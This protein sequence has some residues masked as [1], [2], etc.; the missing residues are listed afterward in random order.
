MCTRRR[1]TGREREQTLL[2]APTGVL[3]AA[4]SVSVLQSMPCTSASSDDQQARAPP[5]PALPSLNRERGSHLLIWQQ[6]SLSTHLLR[7]T[8]GAALWQGTQWLSQ[9]LRTYTSTSTGTLVSWILSP[10]C[11]LTAWIG[12]SPTLT[13][14]SESFAK[15]TYWYFGL[16]V[17]NYH[18]LIIY[19]IWVYY[20]GISK[21][22]IV[23]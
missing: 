9:I 11:L 15:T 12:L 19:S 21:I 14:I 23:R 7:E 22:A 8:L 5:P 4:F 2:S 17:A 16:I 3:S 10:R 6:P 20:K 18:S 13:A 1:K